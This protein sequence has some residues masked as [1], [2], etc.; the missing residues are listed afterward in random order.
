MPSYD[1]RCNQCGRSF[2]LFYKS[3]KD[4]DGATPECP[5]CNSPEVARRIKRVT[6]AKPGRDMSTMSSNEM[7][8]VMDG[9][10]SREIGQMF[11]QVA[12]TTGVDPGATYREAADRLTKGESIQSVEND[13]SSRASAGG[14]DAD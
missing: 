13:L 2:V 9:G 4:Y 8:S 10:N 11:Q 12:D 6:I 1:Y 3:Y 5:H 14:G 7:L